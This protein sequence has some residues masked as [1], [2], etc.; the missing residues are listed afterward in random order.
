MKRGFRP[1]I[2][3]PAAE[4]E[5]YRVD[6][7]G[8]FIRNNLQVDDKGA[9]F[10]DGELGELKCD[11]NLDELETLERL[12]EGA[13][14]YVYKA[15][16][17][18]TGQLMAVKTFSIFDKSN[19]H[20]FIKE[21]HTLYHSDCSFLVDFYGAFF[22]DGHI[23]ISI[24]LMDAGDLHNV[25]KMA[26]RF[27]E[28]MLACFAKQILSGLAYLKSKHQIHRDIKPG[29][30]CVNSN[31]EAKLTDF[32]IASQLDSTMGAANTFVGSSA[33]MAPERIMGQQYSY[34]SDIWSIGIVF[35]E[36]FG[37]EFPFP[38]SAVIIE[39]MSRIV[40]DDPPTPSPDASAEFKDFCAGCLRKDPVKRLTAEEL[41]SHPFITKHS[42]VSKDH[43]SK[44]VQGLMA[45][46]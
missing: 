3:L 8:K 19:R 15:R 5:S 21:L 23:S 42:S 25:L 46:K 33:Y 17:K 36:L 45:K 30:V 34:P 29:N 31:G 18:K 37:G 43:A 12:G 1:K 11:F 32:G 26:G 35:L 41:L 6:E 40:R 24:E 22:K 20:Q 2:S 28:P 27:P 10:R 9:T 44:W 7:N 16:N 38:S 13:S 14:G 4:E 39:T